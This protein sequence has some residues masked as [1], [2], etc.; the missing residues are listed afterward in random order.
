VVISVN[1]QNVHTF[2]TNNKINMN[3][4]MGNSRIEKKPIGS[5]LTNDN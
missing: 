2:E 3:E 5:S 1:E 4:N